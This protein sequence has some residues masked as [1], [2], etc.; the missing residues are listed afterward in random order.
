[1][2]RLGMK[3]TND[4]SERRGAR[5]ERTTDKA[6]VRY[7]LLLRYDVKLLNGM[8]DCDVE[9][10]RHNGHSGF[11]DVQCAMHR[12]QKT[13][14]HGVAVGTSRLDRQSAHFAL[15]AATPSTTTTLSRARSNAFPKT[16][17]VGGV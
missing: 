1:M 13:C 3:A 10:A 15:N 12:Q 16:S 14:P 2:T 4:A 5:A 6:T 11:F 8:S 9:C 17:R 7:Y